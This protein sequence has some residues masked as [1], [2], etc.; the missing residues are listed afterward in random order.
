MGN[1]EK[2]LARRQEMLEKKANDER[3]ENFTDM[4]I[5]DLA[6][7]GSNK[8]QNGKETKDKENSVKESPTD[9]KPKKEEKPKSK[10]NPKKKE[11]VVAKEEPESN[12]PSTLKLLPRR[13]SRK[14]IRSGFSMS[15]L[16]YENIKRYAN[17]AGYRSINDFV[18]D[19]F[20]RL[21]DYLR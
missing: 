19:L 12:P 2:L 8:Q 3:E 15:T 1:R 18:N 21:D 20:E 11:N 5:Q 16:A 6:E 4:L 17:E 7:D 13:K 14:T 10:P 9:T